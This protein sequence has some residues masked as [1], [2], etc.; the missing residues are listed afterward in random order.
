MAAASA[1]KNSNRKQP[2]ILVV[3]DEVLIRLMV[4]NELRAQGFRVLEAVNADE[5]FP[6]LESRV[7]IDLVFTDVK[8]P[9]SMDGIALA[10]LIRERYPALK[11]VVTS[12]YSPVWPSRDFVDAF[13]GKPYEVARVVTR[14][15][16]LLGL[17]KK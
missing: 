6:L 13:F 10:R 2:T 12:D 7:A 3:E 14:L 11:L 15:K 17:A 1:P 16:E 5:A 9:G 8:M 4:A